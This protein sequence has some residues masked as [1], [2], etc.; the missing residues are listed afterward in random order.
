[1]SNRQRPSRHLVNGIELLENTQDCISDCGVGALRITKRGTALISV[2][3]MRMDAKVRLLDVYYAQNLAI[4]IIS[5][6][7]LEAKA[8][9]I[10]YRRHHRVIAGIHGGATF[11]NVKTSDN[12]LVVPLWKVIAQRV[13][14]TI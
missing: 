10:S 7:I 3:V 1:M 2:T 4:N 12:V 6:V 9:G 14:L 5:H 11:L 13:Y 8:Y